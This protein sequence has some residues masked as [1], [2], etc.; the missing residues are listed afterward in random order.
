MHKIG[1]VFDEASLDV[2]REIK[3]RITGNWAAVVIPS[4]VVIGERI[5]IVAPLEEIV[6]VPKKTNGGFVNPL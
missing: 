5:E 1:I 4:H 2:I 6:S 3:P